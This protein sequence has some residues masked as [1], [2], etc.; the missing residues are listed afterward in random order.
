MISK[1]QP[2][3]FTK[4]KLIVA[5][6]SVS[7]GSMKFEWGEKD[8][9]IQNTKIFLQAIGMD[10]A[11]TVNLYI[12][13]KSGWQVIRVVDEN[14]CSEGM[15]DPNLRVEADALITS[16]KNV[17]LFLPT[18]DCYPVVLYDPVNEILALAHMGW[19]STEKRLL[20]EVI[21]KMNEDYSTVSSRLLVY[22]GPGIKKVSYRFENPMQLEQDEWLPYLEKH[23]DGKWSI[24]LLGYNLHQLAVAG[25]PEANIEKTAIDTATDDNY[26][27][28]Y[29]T[30]HLTKPGPMGRFATVAI[31]KD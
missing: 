28:N 27:S 20:A 8:Q 11:Q 12:T 16:K 21:K 30:N 10:V 31:M 13:G 24:D 26:F 17:G 7:D 1:D 5:V 4:D 29:R 18:A 23:I 2:T 25:V 15:L 14:N 3:I 22:I 9:V 19:Q 6:S